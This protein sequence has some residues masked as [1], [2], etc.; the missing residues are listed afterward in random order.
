LGNEGFHLG[1]EV[2]EGV[3]IE[4]DVEEAIELFEGEFLEGV[5]EGFGEFWVASGEDFG[6]GVEDCKGLLFAAFFAFLFDSLFD[7]FFDSSAFGVGDVGHGFGLF[8]VGD[9]GE[10]LLGGFLMVPDELDG[11]LLFV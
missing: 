7:S 1:G 4:G 10:V 2:F 3:G 5:G 8:V 9:V 11:A 6:E